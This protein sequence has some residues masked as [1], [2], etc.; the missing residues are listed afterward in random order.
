MIFWNIVIGI[1]MFFLNLVL[2]PKPQ[3]AK[4]ASLEDF[5]LPVA[6]EGLEIPVLF[7]THWQKAPNCVWYG[8]FEA[9]AIKGPRRYGFFG[10][11][12]VIGHKY[13]LGMHMVLCHG[14]H[15]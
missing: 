8:D 12:Q 1:A 13:K 2:A 6:E 14:V 3:N 7:G 9:D 4:A 15:D 5:D 11:R 10:P